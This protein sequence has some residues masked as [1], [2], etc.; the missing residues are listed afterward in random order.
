MLEP[1]SARTH[2]QTALESVLLGMVLVLLSLAIG[3]AVKGG[4]ILT[5]GQLLGVL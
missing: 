1:I 4:D 5:F 2:S 3:V